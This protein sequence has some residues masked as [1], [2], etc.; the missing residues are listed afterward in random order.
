MIQLD[1][2]EEKLNNPN[3]VLM[4][5]NRIIIARIIEGVSQRIDKCFSF[6]EGKA[7]V[8][9]FEDE[10]KFEGKV[11]NET[12]RIVDLATQ[13]FIGTL[14]DIVTTGNKKEKD[15]ISVFG[16][17]LYDADFGNMFYETCHYSSKSGSGYI[18]IFNEIGDNF[19]SF[20]A[21]NPQYAE[22]VYDCTLAKKHIMSYYIVQ[23]NEGNTY[24][25]GLSKYIIYIY[26]KNRIYAFESPTTYTA[27]STKPDA[28]KDIIVKPFFMWNVNGEDK[29]YVEHGFSDIPLIEV[30]NNEEYHGDAECVFDLIELYNGVQNNRCKNLYDVVN[31]VLFLRNVRLGD[32]EETKKVIKLLKENRILPAEGEDV[33]AKFLTNPLDQVGLQKLS[34]DVFAAIQRI[35]RVPDLSGIDFSQNASDPILKIK[36]KPL[37]DLC[38][39][40]EKKCTKPYKKI[41]EL[42]LNWCKK[43]SND[44]DTFNFDLSKTKL[45]YAHVLPSN[46]I[47]MVSAIANLQNSKMANPEILLQN[48]SFI[49][50]VHEYIKGMDKWNDDIDKR[51]M[52]NNN[53]NNN[54][55]NETNIE[56]HNE[57]SPLS[58][59]QMDNK[60]NFVKG[61]SNILK[62]NNE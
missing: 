61:G 39:D 7:P 50:N 26:T 42:V 3:D 49:D 47:D 22:C 8:T 60:G 55:L 32:D 2:S 13:T 58:T 38:K 25:L 33:D 37:L 24:N 56:R 17:K 41:L 19:P 1:I 57:K 23:A 12:K 10:K 11:F 27:Q 21:L 53:K 31:Y 51:K 34:D 43:N 59:S 54:G 6:Y 52:L 20:R 29:Y 4:I 62:D 46:D 30:P 9:T 35:S 14:P 36:T 18:A 5:A 44:Y 15:K 48:L 28:L 45:V 16:Q 40:K